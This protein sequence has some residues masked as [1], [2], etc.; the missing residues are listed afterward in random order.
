[1]VMKNYK[2]R[3][4]TKDI[5]RKTN[6][7][8]CKPKFNPKLETQKHKA[9]TWYMLEDD[10]NVTL[11]WWCMETKVKTKSAPKISVERIEN[12]GRS[13]P[14]LYPIRDLVQGNFHKVFHVCTD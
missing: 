8:K 9:R 4:S 2:N 1:M 6:H 13:Y 3:N 5:T 10:S 14:Y 7:K 12:N 11:F